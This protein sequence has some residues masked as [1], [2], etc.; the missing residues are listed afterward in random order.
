M[1]R[2]Q[3]DFI[4][5]GGRV[6]RMHT[7]P[8]LQPQ[9]IA[10]HSFG[11][12]WWCWLLSN[13]TPSAVLLMAALQHDLAEHATGDIPAPTKRKLHIQREVAELE[14]EVFSKV[15][16]LDYQLNLNKDESRILKLADNLELAQH[17]IRE[18]TAGNRCKQIKEMLTNVMSY[19]EELGLTDYEKS[20]KAIVENNYYEVLN[21]R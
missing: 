1:S 3:V 16:M 15:A 8:H 6:L 5:R 13:Q 14:A 21:E 2:E 12:A 9:N 20:C 7:V 11:V 10:A 4:E 18:L 19:T 17:C